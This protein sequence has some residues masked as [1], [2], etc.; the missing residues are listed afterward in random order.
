[1]IKDH[2]EALKQRCSQKLNEILIGK[3]PMVKLFIGPMKKK[4]KKL[5]KKEEEKKVTIC[6]TKYL[7]NLISYIANK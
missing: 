5:L 3:T 4:E 7:I 2:L 6:N 1:M